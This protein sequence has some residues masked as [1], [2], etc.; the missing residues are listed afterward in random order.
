MAVN[1]KDRFAQLPEARRKAILALADQMAAEE[2]TLAEL[3][4]ARQ[5]SQAELAKKLGVQQSAVS[6][7]ERRADMYLSTLSGM[8][9]AMGGTLEIIARFPDRPPVRINQ[10]KMLARSA[11]EHADF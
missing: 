11:S 4:E 8:V 6:T 5:R 9:E 1:S 10:L 2:L 7:I 3:R